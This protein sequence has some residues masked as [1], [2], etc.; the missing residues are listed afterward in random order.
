MPTVLPPELELV[1]PYAAR[2]WGAPRA[3]AGGVADAGVTPLALTIFQAWQLVS[4]FATT[5]LQTRA[6]CS[7]AAGAA[8]AL[9]P[10][11]A[12][13]V[14]TSDATPTAATIQDFFTGAPHETAGRIP[15]RPAK[16]TK[17]GPGGHKCK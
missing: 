5:A 6:G 13:A 8:D 12:R 3:A 11:V 7:L 2:I 4:P 1:S 17:C 9:D 15:R 10:P 14:A 16:C